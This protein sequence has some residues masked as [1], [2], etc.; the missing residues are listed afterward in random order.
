VEQ[1]N[2]D[3]IGKWEWEDL[4]DPAVEWWLNR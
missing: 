3:S 1:T 2:K 4:N